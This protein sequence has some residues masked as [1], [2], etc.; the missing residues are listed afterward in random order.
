MTTHFLSIEFVCL[1]RT[2]R[3]NS[4]PVTHLFI[5]NQWRHFTHFAVLFQSASTSKELRVD[6]YTDGIHCHVYSH[7]ESPFWHQKPAREGPRLCFDR[8]AVDIRVADVKQVVEEHQ[9]NGYHL[10]GNNCHMFTYHCLCACLGSSFKE[11]FPD[12]GGFATCCQRR[13]VELIWHPN[14]RGH[15]ETSRDTYTIEA[16][17]GTV[18]GPFLSHNGSQT[19]DLWHTNTTSG[20]QLWSINRLGGGIYHIQAVSHADRGPYLSHDCGATVD[21][22]HTASDNQQWRICHVDGEKFT[23]AA[24]SHAARGP[25]LSHNRIATVDLWMEAGVNQFWTIPGFKLCG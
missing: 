15:F 14:F 17:V 13:F 9:R 4:G 24:A 12:F 25:Y 23:I 1:S 5:D 8:A 19:V 10:L 18:R 3:T 21:L 2:C 11:Q 20:K 6:R 22:W 16:S 7:G